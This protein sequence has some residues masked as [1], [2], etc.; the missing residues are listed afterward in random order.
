MKTEICKTINVIMTI[1]KKRFS[2]LTLVVQFQQ[3][4]KFGNK[5]QIESVELENPR[6]VENCLEIGNIGKE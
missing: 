4:K 5:L 3:M 6:L 2:F 1:G